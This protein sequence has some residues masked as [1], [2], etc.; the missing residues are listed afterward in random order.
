MRPPRTACNCMVPS[1]LTIALR[2]QTRAN[3]DFGRNCETLV[4][5]KAAKNTSKQKSMGTYHILVPE[6]QLSAI[7]VSRNHAKENRKRFDDALENMFVGKE[8]KEAEGMR[9]RYHTASDEYIVAV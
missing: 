6:L 5:G 9:K 2:S 7:R 4:T 1:V 3:N 8:E